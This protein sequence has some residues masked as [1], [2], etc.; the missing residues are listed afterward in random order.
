MIEILDR[1]RTFDNCRYRGQCVG[2]LGV[3]ATGDFR[4]TYRKF[5]TTLLN[6]REF[7]I[8]CLI[9]GPVRKGAVLR[10]E[11]PQ[12]NMMSKLRLIHWR[13]C[14]HGHRT[15]SLPFRSQRRS[16]HSSGVV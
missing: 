8:C 4:D 15:G 2:A 14:S 12:Q 3:T 10:P 6:E 13:V 9:L 16:R 11:R 1:P 5:T 7:L